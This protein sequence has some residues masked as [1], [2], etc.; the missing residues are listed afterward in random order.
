[1][2]LIKDTRIKM[3]EI[4]IL[5]PNARSP[6]FEGTETVQIKNIINEINKK[7][8]TKIIWVIFQPSKTQVKENEREQIINFSDYGNA[9]EILNKFNPDL[10]IT[11]TEFF[12]Q[13]I[14]FVLAAKF[15]KIPVVTYCFVSYVNTN[16]IIN[17][18]SRLRLLFSKKVFGEITE[19]EKKS[20]DTSMIQFNIR[21]LRFISKTLKEIKYNKI[22]IYFSI[23]SFILKQFFSTSLVPVEK[24][25]E[26]KLNLCSN[27]KWKEYLEK[28]NFEKS[29]IV[30]TG[31]PY[32][33]QLFIKFKNSKPVQNIET[34]KIK[35]LFC[36][37]PMNEHGY[38]SKNEEDKII[39]KTIDNILK[40]T[41]FELGI[42]IHPS[43]SSKEEYE[44][45]INDRKIPIYQKEKLTEKLEQFDVMITYGASSAILNA[46]M[47]KKPVVFLDVF[48]YTKNLN[49][50]Y[51]KLIS[52]KCTNLDEISQK[53]MFSIN[54][55]IKEENYNEYIKQHLEKFDGNSA[56]RASNAIMDVL[57]D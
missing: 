41:N 1:M 24:Q 19:L 8:K 57:K 9:V 46:I 49:L 50:F 22:H 37:S 48:S 42:K 12:S 44:K 3:N 14:A 2:N 35:I 13:S 18:K 27:T 38:V 34:N 29:T 5:I 45:L 16:L 26:G 40:N 30:V 21:K 47:L 54:N 51:D 31:D 56:I 53:I 25:I 43:T 7:N 15:K 11:E 28:N 55:E 39:L 20:L 33:D 32:L 6:N 36:T 52:I 4:T 17:I 10:V 23:I